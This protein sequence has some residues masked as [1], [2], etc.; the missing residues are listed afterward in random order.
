MA[1]KTRIEEMNNGP[2]DES[3]LTVN[4]LEVA[5]GA[6]QVIWGVSMSIKRNQIVS[7]IGSN[8]AGKT[9]TLRALAGLLPTLK[10]NVFFQ[11]ENI[12]RLPSHERVKR[13]VIMSP[14]GRQ[15]WARMSVEEN[16][17][18]GAYSPEFRK[19]APANLHKIYKMFPRLKERHGQLA[20]TLSGG[21]QQMC[22]IG[23]AMMAEPCLLMLDEPSLGLAPK[24]VKEIFSFI[25]QIAEQ[26]VTVLLVEQ[27]MNYALKISDYA[28]LLE[29]GRITMNGTGEEMLNDE[30]VRHSYLGHPAKVT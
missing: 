26:G 24:L 1:A 22:A 30:Y 25:K 14:E 3:L 17:L 27:N 20:G 18:M 12:T 16:L 10:G 15:L 19:R 2:N 8:G 28:Y 23:R 5:Y 29:T 6:V 11:G 4:D 21:E 7:I 9:T 13:R